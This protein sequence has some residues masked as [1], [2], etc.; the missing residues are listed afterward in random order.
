[1]YSFS[2]AYMTNAF[3]LAFCV[4]LTACLSI[5]CAAAHMIIFFLLFAVICAYS[6]YHAIQNVNLALENA[7]NEERLRTM[8]LMLPPSYSSKKSGD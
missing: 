2:Q 6:T 4:G 3:A 8:N 1:M 5:S 7:K